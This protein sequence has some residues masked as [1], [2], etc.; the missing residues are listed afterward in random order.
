M[1]IIGIQQ[2]KFQISQAQI[3]LRRILRNCGLVKVKFLRFNSSVRLFNY[4]KS[5][6]VTPFTAKQLEVTG[7]EPAKFSNE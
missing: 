3:C 7:V 6:A 1:S 5:I 4:A 2:I